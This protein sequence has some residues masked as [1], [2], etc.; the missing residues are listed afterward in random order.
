MIA[1]IRPAARVSLLAL[2]LTATP[3]VAR[4]DSLSVRNSFR[5]GT[6]GV[7]CSALNTPNDQRLSSMFDRAYRLTCRDAAGSIGSVVALRKD[8]SIGSVASGITASPL[9]CGETGNGE[10]E[11]LGAVTTLTCRDDKLGIDYRRYAVRQ[12]GTSYIVE[13]LA[14]YDPALRIALASIVSDRAVPGE[15]RV[16]T[17]EVSDAAAFARVQAGQLD[18]GDARAEAYRRNNGARFAEASEF[19]ESIANRNDKGGSSKAE[20][21]ANTGLQQSNLGNFRTAN[22]LFAEASAAVARGDGVTQRMLRNFRAINFLNQLQPDA[23]LRE[24]ESR[25]ESVSAVFD[26]DLLNQGI[27]SEPLS[28]QINREN[29]SLQRISGISSGLT[30]AERAQILDAQAIALSATAA[31]QQGRF[32]DALAQFDTA[33]KQLDS[34]RDGRVASTAWLRSEFEIEQALIAEAQGRISDA[35]SAFDRSIRVTEASFPESPALLAARARKAAFLGR[36]GEVDGALE[37][38]SQVVDESPSIPDSGLT[39]RQLLSPYFSLL[40][41]TRH[42]GNV[43]AMFRASQVLQR[44]GVAQT[45]AVLARELSEGND[46]AASMFRLSVARSRQIARLELEVRALSANPAQTPEEGQRLASASGTLEGLRAEQTALQSKLAAFPKYS[47]LAPDAVT[48]DQLQAALRDGEAYYKLI[49]VGNN[50]YALY[51]TRD[52]AEALPIDGTVQQL[53]EDVAALRATL[54]EPLNGQVVV[55][56]FD[57]EA[58]HA[59]YD[60]LFGPVADRILSVSHLIVEPDGALLKLPA[61]VLVMDQASV[62]DYNRRM[63]KRNADEYDFRGVAWLGRDRAMSVAVSPRGFMESRALEPSRA[64]RSYLGLGSNAVP[65]ERPVVAVAD[66]CQWPLAVWQNPIASDELFLAQKQFGD[67]GSAVLTGSAFS[68]SALLSDTTLADYKVLHFATHG[69]LTAPRADC[70]ARPALVTSFGSSGSDGLLTFREI[71]DLKLNADLVILSACDTAGE[72]SVGASREAGV[73]TGGNY[74]LDGL[75]RAFVGAGARSVIASH[76]PVPDDFDATKRLI[77][78]LFDVTSGH[79]IAQSL[80]KSQVSLMDDANT[81]HPFY[82]AAF[83]ILGDGARSLGNHDRLGRSA[84]AH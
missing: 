1:A 14:G 61:S 72:A 15:I 18:A 20:A 84:S 32:D 13:G 70:P 49:E 22:R 64:Q 56:P 46:E 10:I 3:G 33:A 5:I 26:R 63:K 19:F 52:Y 79:T 50:I 67:A 29:S 28:V 24:L 39:L 83:I 58:S 78:G 80:A 53:E 11:G 12:G 59:L 48:L 30:P 38:F 8:T 51:I 35:A 23:A 36:T 60:K 82:W 65:A 69:L 2:A 81:S 77:S 55:L 68:D 62:D 47:A 73:T 6:S 16:A 7:S 76:W 9:S 71:F 43:A 31:R 25:V 42:E 75:V 4:E 27:I 41:R 57:I 37:I 74:A 45:Q 54:G 34:V 40:V 66:E 21:L 44:P 17:T